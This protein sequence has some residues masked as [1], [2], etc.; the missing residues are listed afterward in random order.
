MESKQ[1]EDMNSKFDKALEELEQTL[2][3]EMPSGCAEATMRNVLKIL[4]IED[5]RINNIM[6]PLSGGLGGYKSEKGWLGPCGAVVGGCGSVGLI[7]GGKS[8]KEL[9]S[10]LVLPAYLKSAQFAKE[11]EKQFGSVLCSDLS[12]YDF[13]DPNKIMEYIEKGVWGKQCYKYVLWAIDNV[14][15]L[16]KKELK[17]G[18]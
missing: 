17:K 11:F 4:G 5:T 16:M 2:P 15:N 10:N 8:N 1:A 3:K 13:S 6:V 18:W 9:P 12:G 14:R 7:L